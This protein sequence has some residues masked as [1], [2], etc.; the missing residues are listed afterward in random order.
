MHFI[1]Q[2]SFDTAPV[3]KRAWLIADTWEWRS[4][5]PSWPSL[6]GSRGQ[7]PPHSFWAEVGIQGPH[8][9]SADTMGINVM[10]CPSSSIKVPS[11]SA[12]CSPPFRVF[13]CF[14]YIKHPGILAVLDRK[15][16]RN[17]VHFIFLDVKILENIWTQ[18][19]WKHNL[20]GFVR[21]R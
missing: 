16:R 5:F 4:R 3:G 17:Y 15:N 13:L 18:C 21:C 7:V 10:P 8:Q 9:A 1:Y 11:L 2:A 6:L 12:F 19:W 14:F 20:S